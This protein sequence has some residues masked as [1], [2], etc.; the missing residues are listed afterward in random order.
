ME[1]TSTENLSKE[2]STV[3]KTFY[4]M[5]IITEIM[6]SKEDWYLENLKVF[7]NSIYKKLNLF[8]IADENK[9]I[10][11]FNNDND[12]LNISEKIEFKNFLKYKITNL[13]KRFNNI[14]NK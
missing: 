5:Q 1:L 2:N 13:K 11:I 6:L 8:K 7:K 14:I 10:K 12:N 3:K 9:E 4:F